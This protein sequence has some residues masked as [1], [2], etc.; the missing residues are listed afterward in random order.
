MNPTGKATTAIV[1]GSNEGDE[2]EEGDRVVPARQGSAPWQGRQ[3]PRRLEKGLGVESVLG[4]GR[5]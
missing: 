2:R 4:T 1:D 5:W 3:W